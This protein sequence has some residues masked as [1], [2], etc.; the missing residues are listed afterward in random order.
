ME[1]F[2][3]TSTQNSQVQGRN[4]GIDL[5][6]SILAIMIITRHSA[7]VSFKT[8]ASSGINVLTLSKF[9]YFSIQNLGV[10][11]FFLI[12]LS[13]YVQK[14]TQ[15]SNYFARRITRLMQIL[16]FWWPIYLLLT[17]YADYPLVPD[18][19]LGL[20]LIP[21][22]NGVLYFLGALVICTVTVELIERGYE[23]L[24]ETMTSYYMYFVLVVSFLISVILRS[25]LIGGA[26]LLR[27]FVGLGPLT[28][29]SYP[30]AIS[31]FNHESG[32]LKKWLPLTIIALIFQTIEITRLYL[33]MGISESSLL[34]VLLLTYGSPFV[35]P[36]AL[37]VIEF[38][39]SLQIKKSG[40]IV[41][42]I[43]KNSLGIYLFQQIVIALGNKLSGNKLLW[44]DSRSWVDS[45]TGGSI[46]LN[47]VGTAIVISTTISI[48]FIMSKVSFLKKFVQ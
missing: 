41:S 1:I 37:M 39:R 15:N 22:L 46:S 48:V 32:R 25:F 43:A 16:L 42:W 10:P 33:T 5:L 38:F 34:Q 6:K 20:L 14:R 21:I 3:R 23:K 45:A 17:Q 31:F 9:F 44:I 11:V 30:A 35:V 24:P 13:F 26:P 40:T 8:A 29:V 27:A 28:F 12:S 7:L 4:F 18:S 47:L 36:I 2:S 19:W